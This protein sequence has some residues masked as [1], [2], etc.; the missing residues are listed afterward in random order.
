[1]KA[2]GWYVDPYGRHEARW[3]SDGSP[4][5]LVQDRGVESHDPAPDTPTTGPLEPFAETASSGADDLLRA[6][7]EQEPVDSD[8]ARNAEWAIF[9]ESSGQD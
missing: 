8:V 3:F 1:M 6:D 7:S 9:D 4:T 5:D 2:E